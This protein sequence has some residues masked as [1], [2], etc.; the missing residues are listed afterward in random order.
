MTRYLQHEGVDE[1][2]K[3][4]EELWRQ[5]A[6]ATVIPRRVIERAPV[7]TGTYREQWLKEVMEY[8]FDD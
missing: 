7:D 3:R 8:P 2:A 1:F 5:I 4:M 6:V